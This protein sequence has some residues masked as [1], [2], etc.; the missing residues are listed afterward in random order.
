MA[1]EPFAA[2]CAAY[3]VIA[4]AWM[5]TFTIA[6]RLLG[7]ERVF[8]PGSYDVTPL[9]NLLSLVLG[10][11][12]AVL[13]GWVCVLIDPRPRA[14]V[15]LMILI[16][17]LGLVDVAATVKKSK[18]GPSARGDSVDNRTAMRHSRRPA[19]VAVMNI[20]VGVAG[21]AVV[22]VQCFPKGN[23]PR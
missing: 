10:L 15:S 2:V 14:F 20:L 7:S 5:V 23:W 18:T 9:W 19:W 11:V 13:G 4:V 12:A 17:V 6:Y 3:S 1:W 21:V 16:A 22:V 8:R